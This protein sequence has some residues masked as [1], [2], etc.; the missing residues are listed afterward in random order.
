VKV[1]GNPLNYKSSGE[2]A[3]MGASPAA[4]PLPGVLASV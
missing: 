2:F 4:T 1:P 3:L